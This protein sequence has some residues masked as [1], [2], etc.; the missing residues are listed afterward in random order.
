M[1]QDCMPSG[2]AAQWLESLNYNPKTLGSIPWRGQD[3]VQLLCLF[4][5]TL[6]HYLFVTPF[7]C[8]A[9]THNC[10][11]VKDPLSICRKRGL[12]VGDMETQKHST[13]DIF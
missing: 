3:I 9:L 7:V 12:T 6:V 1:L 5:S 13:H 4:E 2:D 10:A 11:H 8:M